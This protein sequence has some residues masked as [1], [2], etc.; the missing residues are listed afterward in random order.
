MHGTM[1]LT[2]NARENRNTVLPHDCWLFWRGAKEPFP[3]STRIYPN[4]IIVPLSGKWASS[5]VQTEFLKRS[6]SASGTTRWSAHDRH[7]QFDALVTRQSGRG[8]SVDLALG[9]KKN[10]YREK[11]FFFLERSIEREFLERCC[12]NFF[13]FRNNRFNNIKFLEKRWRIF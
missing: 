11:H 4:R 9:G 7:V 6:P 5:I 2:H 8:M 3:R 1:V 12:R 10:I 13:F